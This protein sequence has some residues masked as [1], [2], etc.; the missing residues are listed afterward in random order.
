MADEAHKLWQGSAK[1]KSGL[2]GVR[3]RS[4][5]IN[6]VKLTE[7]NILDEDGEAALG[8]K[9]GNYFSIELP[10]Y[11]DRGADDFAGCVDVIAATI[12]KCCPGDFDRILVAALGNPD[13]TPDALG[14]LAADS[15]LVTRH[16]DRIEFPQFC[17]L[18]LCRPG[19]LGN[20]GIE[21]AAHIEAVCKLV[22]P[23]LVVVIDALAGSD[24]DRL[25]RCVQISDTGISPGSGVGN[26]RNEICSAGLGVP[27]I[28]IGIPTVI[29]AAYIGG[30]DFKGMF[31]TPRS[32]D[33]LIRAVARLIGYGINLAF[34]K[35]IG[36]D[37]IDALI[38]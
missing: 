11:F 33:S 27:V 22:Q 16:L 1:G 19:V 26:D 15:L 31:V 37:D 32:V 8:E 30:E 5:S 9:I 6:Q 18:S 14:S 35:G 3:C 17:S 23:Q 21:S 20:S 25:C 13:I 4:Y 10:K 7:V 29:D 12:Q 28:S 2:P 38:G 34:H 36:L 24:A